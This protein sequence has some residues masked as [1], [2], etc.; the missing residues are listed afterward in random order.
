MMPTQFVDERLRLGTEAMQRLHPGLVIARITGF[1]EA[2]DIAV[3]Y[4]PWR[5]CRCWS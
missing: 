2:P 4:W 3:V 5:T 1:G